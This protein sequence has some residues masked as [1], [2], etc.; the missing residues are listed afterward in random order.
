[1][2]ERRVV[3]RRG[4][5]PAGWRLR[6]VQ[7]FDLSLNGLSVELPMSAQRVLAFL[8]VCARPLNRSYVCGTLW[9][10]SSETRA[11]G[12]LRS[13]LW[14]LRH[15]A[16]GIVEARG[17][18]LS[19]APSVDVDVRD[20]LDRAHRVL[21]GEAD[22]D[23]MVAMLLDANGPAHDLLPDWYDEWLVA[24]RDRLRQLQLHALEA[25]STRLC[26]RAEY[27]WAVEA[28]QL[29][30][31]AEPMRESAARALIEA[32]LAEGNVDLAMREFRRFCDLLNRELG[33]E[34]TRLLT[35][36][37]PTGRHAQPTVHGHH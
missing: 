33:V 22:G 25:L 37:L 27:G 17:L 24:E 3:A 1:V 7:G 28:A 14:R 16:P 29:A 36:L 19:L 35:E 2:A 23:D 31:A 5:T 11:H 9:A 8:A 10:D 12:S 4:T 13:A 15:S 32:H 21:R 18:R 30:V 6:L 26:A 20:V 34:P